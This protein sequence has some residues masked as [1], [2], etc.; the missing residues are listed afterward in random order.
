MGNEA[1]RE[2]YPLCEFRKNIG[3]IIIIIWSTACLGFFHGEHYEVL[4]ITRARNLF[5]EFC[6]R[7]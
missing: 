5:Y 7:L 6:Y 4:V 3:I 1:G 2:G